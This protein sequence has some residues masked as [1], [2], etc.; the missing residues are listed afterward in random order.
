MARLDMP[1]FAP[2]IPPGTVT[3]TEK[4]HG[5]A[6]V[7]PEDRHLSKA[8]PR[9]LPF[10]LD[11]D[12]LMVTNDEPNKPVTFRWARKSYTI[13]P[14]DTAPVP[15]EA[16][17]NDLGDPRSAD[18][19]VTDFNDGNGGKGIVMTRHAELSR[20]F[21]IYAIEG[22]NLESWT[23]QKT[24]ETKPGL[25]DKTPRVRVETLAGQPVRFP[26][27]NP[28]MLPLPA[29]V[30]DEHKVNSDTTRMIDAV[31]AENE[32][33]RDRVAALETFLQGE[34]ERRAGVDPAAS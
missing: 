27:Q 10:L 32:Q 25:V 34:V 31:A 22:E 3:T 20:L 18:N 11:G 8:T 30:V 17:V 6:I 5:R 2:Q 16:L 29:M 21:A 24:G 9:D 1:E 7:Q 26:G 23:D 19:A 4:P 28:N 13:E 33:L 15:F 12:L 14:G